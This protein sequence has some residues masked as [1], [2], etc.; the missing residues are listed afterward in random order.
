MPR[1]KLAKVNFFVN[2]ISTSGRHENKLGWE[3]TT[4]G[5]SDLHRRPDD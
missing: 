4:I 1:M 5:H 2:A 3:K